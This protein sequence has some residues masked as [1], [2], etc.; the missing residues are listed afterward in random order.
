VQLQDIINIL[1]LQGVRA[2]NIHYIREDDRKIKEVQVKLKPLNPKQTCPCCNGNDVIHKGNDGYRKIRHLKLGIV[3]C[4]LIVPCLRL[5]CKACTA[6]YAYTYEFVKGKE[7]YTE[8]FKAQ[9]YEIAIGSTVEHSAYMTGTPYSTAERFFKETAQKVAG[10]TVKQAQVTAMNSKKLILGV[11][12][13]ATR[14]GHNYNTG[15]HDLRGESLIGI[16]E[17]RTLPEQDKLT[18]GHTPPL[19]VMVKYRIILTKPP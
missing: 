5:K 12:D 7:R 14:K 4:A 3:P 6:T 13:F 17:G 9:I 16:A 19:V 11:D 18:R 1:G 10:H 15:I 8:E 2:V